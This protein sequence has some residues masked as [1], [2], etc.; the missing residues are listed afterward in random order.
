V[1]NVGSHSQSAMQEVTV[2]DSATPDPGTDRYINQILEPD[3]GPELPFA[4]CGRD[5]II[6]KNNGQV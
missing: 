2:D 5:S 6:L 4:V 1:A 3:A